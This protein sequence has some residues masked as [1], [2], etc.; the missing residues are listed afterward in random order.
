MCC[1]HG[2]ECDC[3]E[4]TPLTNLFPD[5]DSIAITM[6]AIEAII[7]IILFRKAHSAFSI[8]R[9]MKLSFFQLFHCFFIRVSTLNHANCSFCI[10][11]CSFINFHSLF[12]RAKA[13]IFHLYRR[14]KLR[15]IKSVI[16]SE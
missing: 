13:K 8:T 11:L 7:S 3:L 9:F 16:M 6:L 12:H 5:T 2:D 14:E 15:Y 10:M 1:F 4:K